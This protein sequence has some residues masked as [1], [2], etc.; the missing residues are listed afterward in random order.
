V[1]VTFGPAPVRGL[2][3]LDGAEAGQLYLEP[4]AFLRGGDAETDALFTGR[5]NETACALKI[6]RRHGPDRVTAALVS[7]G[8]FRE[9]RQSAGADPRA[10]RL[11]EFADA[12]AISRSGWAGLTFDRP[13]V[14]GIVNA[15][16]DSF[17][18]GG[19]YDT[20]EAAIAAAFAMR[21][22]G[23]AIIDVGG[24]SSR[25]GARPVAAEIEAAR[26]LPII[27]ALARENVVV[28][29]D[30]RKP[31]VMAAALD[32]GAIIVN[33]IGALQEPGAIAV[34]NRAGCGVVLMH[35]QGEPATMQN[36]PVY[37]HPVLD[38]FDFLEQRLATCVAAGIPRSAVVVDPGIG[39]G[40][41]ALDNLAILASLGLFRT[42]GCGVLVGVS[43][44]ATIGRLT[45]IDRP[46]DRLIPSVAAGLTAIAAGAD[47]LRVHDVAE[48]VHAIRVVT[49]VEAARV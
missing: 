31:T 24:E 5:P 2:A 14:M 49:A 38:V 36:A 46:S 32:A 44:K 15:T 19:R 1:P 18:D 11:G 21:D 26:V 42:L 27:L 10:I 33:D 34:A 43:R 23:A 6:Y 12:L 8:A 13:L 22:A 4:C 17:S 16:P 7:P 39:F 28:S 47:I 35:M 48:T 9:W 40:K 30:T 45:G 20:T 29:V 37:R 41:T 25:P 3:I